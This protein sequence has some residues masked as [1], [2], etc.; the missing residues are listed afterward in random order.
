VGLS[1]TLQ[2]REWSTSGLTRPPVAELEGARV[3]VVEAIREVFALL[4]GEGGG[5]VGGGEGGGWWWW[6]WER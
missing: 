6:W 5:E 1:R 4:G 2:R 3:E